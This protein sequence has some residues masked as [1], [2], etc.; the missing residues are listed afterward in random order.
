MSSANGTWDFVIA[1][2][3]VINGL[4]VVRLLSA[5]SVF[6]RHRNSAVI[7]HFWVYYVLAVFQLMIHVLLWWSIVGLREAGEVNFLRFLYLLVGPTLLFLATSVLI[8]EIEGEEV[9]LRTQYLDVCKDYYT[10]LSV[11]WLWVIFI[12][13]VFVA[14]WYGL[15][16]HP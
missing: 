6:L 13:P 9:D 16:P 11:F 2:V 15:Y 1:L 8:T 4:G 12:W 7:A 14:S 10:I 3:A 5:C